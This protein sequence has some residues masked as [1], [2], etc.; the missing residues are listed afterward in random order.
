MIVL[1]I[2][3]GMLLM[4]SSKFQS[5]IKTHVHGGILYF[6]GLNRRQIMCGHWLESAEES[7][8]GCAI[9]QEL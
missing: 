2:G 4:A 6:V 8:P 9:G 7:L 5:F 1:V 3:I